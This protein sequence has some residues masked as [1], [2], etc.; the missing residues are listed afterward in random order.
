MLSID[1][2]WSAFE[3]PRQVFSPAQVRLYRALDRVR[4][5]GRGRLKPWTLRSAWHRVLM[6]THYYNWRYQTMVDTHITEQSKAIAAKI[7][8]DA[9]QFA[10]DS[11][12]K[13]AQA[14]SNS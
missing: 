11:A 14:L 3:R 1:F 8:A 2:T 10:L 9:M 6:H 4:M 12:P 5:P 7:D 13:Q